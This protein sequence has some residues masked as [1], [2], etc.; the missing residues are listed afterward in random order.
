MLDIEEQNNI[1]IGKYCRMSD[2]YKRK[3]FECIREAASLGEPK[4]QYQMYLCYSQGTGVAKDWNKA[5]EWL[6]KSA[7]NGEVK[8][9]YEMG[10]LHFLG[11]DAFKQSKN[12]V[13]GFIW[14]KINKVG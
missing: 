2:H 13:M 5:I 6:K 11:I 3:A 14:N 4:A 12:D 7:N 1:E 9:Q 8:A 10:N